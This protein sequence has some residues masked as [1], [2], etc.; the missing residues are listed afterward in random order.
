MV[1]EVAS[2][3]VTLR[4]LGAERFQANMRDSGSISEQTGARVKRAMDGIAASTDRVGQASVGLNRS[5]SALNA[6]AVSA[7]RAETS[8]LAL[9]KAFTLLGTAVG[10]LAGGVALNAFK[11]YADQATSI[12]NRLATVVP[13]QAQ[14]AA[15]DQQIFETA[16]R[17]RSSY[18]ATANIFSRMSLASSTIGASQA[19]ILRVVETTQKALQAGGATSSESASIA[20]QLTQALGSGRLAGDELKSISE[21]STVLIKAIADEF[22]VSVG[23]LKDM[24][25]AGELEAGRVFQAILKA[26]K[27]VDEVFARSTPTIA[28]GIQQVDNALTRYIGNVDKSIGATRALVGGLEFVARNL[29]GIGDSVALAV[30]ALAGPLGARLLGGTGSR[31]AAP[32]RSAGADARAGVADTAATAA[33]ARAARE[34]AQVE[35]QQAQRALQA[36]DAQPRFRQ[37]APDVQ[38]AYERQAAHVDKLREAS[39]KTAEREATAL[40]KRSD[41]ETVAAQVSQ[42][43]TNR[44]A[45]AK[46]TLAKREAALNDIIAKRPA[47]EQAAANAGVN[48]SRRQQGGYYD[49][50]YRVVEQ[51]DKLAETNATIALTKRNIEALDEAIAR[52]RSAKTASDFIPIAMRRRQ[53]ELDRLPGLTGQRDDQGRILNESEKRLIEAERRIGDAQASERDKAGRKLADL[54]NQ[55]SRA[56]AAVAGQAEKVVAAE[57]RANETLIASAEKRAR[58]QAELD[59][60]AIA[61][62]NQRR[63]AQQAL[64]EA[65]GRLGGLA[66]QVGTSA[67]A[68][69]TQ[70]IQQVEA[71]QS[72][73]NRA[74]FVEQEAL[75]K[76]AEAS[77]RASAAKV[78]LAGAARA[79]TNALTGMVSM[80]GGP[81]GAALTAA[82][83]GLIGYELIQARATAR[84]EEHT[85]ALA[86]LGDRLQAIKS[87]SATGELRSDRDVVGDQVA[88]TQAAKAVRDRR[89]SLLSVFQKAQDRNSAQSDLGGGITVAG[90]L[91]RAAANLGVNLSQVVEQLRTLPPV[92][93]EASTAAETLARVL[94]ET[95]RIDPKFGA[96]ASELVKFSDEMRIAGVTLREFEEARR[97]AAEAAKGRTNEL[98]FGIEDFAEADINA[99]TQ[100]GR[101]AADAFSQGFDTQIQT[102]TQ[103][104]DSILGEG[105]RAKAAFQEALGQIDTTVLDNALRAVGSSLDTVKSN[106]DGAKASSG[107]AAVASIA[108]AQALQLIQQN[109]P[110][111]AATI[112]QITAVANAYR[113]VIGLQSVAAAGPLAPGSDKMT[114]EQAA[115]AAARQREQSLKTFNERLEA[116]DK[117]PGARQRR[118][119]RALPGLTDAEISRLDAAENPARKGGGRKSPEQRN[120]ETLAKKLEELDQDASVAALNDFDQKTVRFAQSAKVASEQIQ[121][122]I[123]AAKSGDLTSV[124]PVMQ[125]IYEKMRLLEG[126]KLGKAAL[127]DIFPGRLLAEQIESVRR[128]AQSS[129]E[130][131]A[132]LDLIEQ[133]LR[134]KGAPEWAKDFTSSFTDMVKG[135]ATG[136]ATMADALATFKTRVMNLA[137]DAAFKPLERMLTGFLGGGGDGLTGFSNLFSGLFSGGAAGG[138]PTGGVRLFA[139]GGIVKGPGTGTSDSILARI[140]NGEA[141]IPARVVA[142]NRPLVEALVSN[143]LPKFADGLMPDLGALTA[144]SL[145]MQEARLAASPSPNMPTNREGGMVTEVY[146]SGGDKTGAETTMGPRGPR[147]EITID[148][149]IAAALL[150]GSETRAALKKLT[151]GRMTGG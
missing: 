87:Q 113:Q 53:A 112:A 36:L 42:T 58:V 98:E 39:A 102:G 142:T 76:A 96:Q 10:G 3:E 37:A 146:V 149:T 79:T 124:P 140:S 132:N 128:A 139:D 69:R 60:K 11:N 135:V 89:D 50:L 145:S 35:L 54:D 130:I 119:G 38:Q 118:I 23:K 16:Q 148:K 17:T 150:S 95:A 13:I 110:D 65:E 34:A 29:D 19:D 6:V 43:A 52:E 105:E 91:D 77:N 9:N 5:N 134:E 59:A 115:A 131:A 83:I 33:A 101:E 125:E 78:A 147:T 111:L 12:Q 97:A 24:G 45:S 73:L 86:A 27:E 4:L 1:A 18:E 104:T 51:R 62:S 90:P 46:D 137:L 126:V 21:N 55:I 106:L 129:P 41:A 31:V 151:G 116:A 117:T 122:F 127:N 81:L 99:A 67:A 20:T 22:G 93:A 80:L 74:H 94:T 114:P 15:I 72:V 14:R 28:A 25:A 30:G 123:A 107:E 121:A 26:G 144:R 75:G 63:A 70:A 92:S 108:F 61:A 56:R 133:R 40:L 85:R 136:T 141:I 138:S 48:V 100:Q 2:I 32:F 8:V 47:L 103:I 88:L 82:S 120:A 44:V 66:G 57:V 143:R 7:L 71:A 68:Q 64:S 109:Q 49:A 84:V